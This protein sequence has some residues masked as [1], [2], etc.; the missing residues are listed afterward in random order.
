MDNV[1]RIS[2]RFDIHASPGTSSEAAHVLKYDETFAVFDNFGNIRTD[3]RGDQ[4]L[5]HQGTRYLNRYRFLL[6]GTEPL[7]LSSE[8]SQDNLILSVDLTNPDLYREDEL[9]VDQHVLHITR[10]KFLGDGV[11]YDRVE[12]ANYTNALLIVRFSV[13]FEA[14]FADIFE[15]R[16]TKRA[17]RGRFTEPHLT[18][19]S[20]RLSYIGLDEVTR[21]TCLSFDPAPVELT[22]Y[23]AEFEAQLA[24]GERKTQDIAVACNTETHIEPDCYDRIYTTLIEERTQLD[25][26]RTT[27]TTANE[28]FNTWLDRS[29][30]D[31]RMMTTATDYGP[32]PYAGVPWFSTVFGRD[33]IITALETL[34]L[35][36]ELARG[37]LTFLAATQAS[38]IDPARDAE[39]GKIVH[40]LRQGE[41]AALGEVPFGRYYGSVD[42]TP[43][44]VL[45]AGH[46][47]DRTGDLNTITDLWPHLERALSWI[48]DYGDLDGDG[49]VEYA[50]KS[51]SGLTNQGWKDSWDC[52]FHADGSFAEAPIA[53][54]EVQGYVFAAKQA[55]AAIATA[56][57]KFE[58]A[59][60]LTAEADAL[61]QRF[62]EAFWVEEL[63]TYAIALDVNKAPCRIRTSNPGHCLFS[64][65]ALPR[66]ADRVAASL[67]STRMFSGWGVRTLATGEARYNPM[68]Y[69]NGSV[70]P[71]DNA[72]I[73]AGLARYGHSDKALEILHG[74]F[75]TSL[76]FRNSRLPELFCGFDRQ[77]YAGPTR[78]PT[79]AS[80][81]SWAAAVVFLL[82]GVAIGA[83]IDASAER[84]I[85]RNPKIPDWL[86]SMTIANL[87]V[88]QSSV[89]LHLHR[90]EHDVAVNVTHRTGPAEIII[91]K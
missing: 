73:A 19:D 56:L 23:E 59:D 30:A 90:Y 58:Q 25:H 82:C 55:A 80:P 45:L 42:A 54:C 36:P 68:S 9:L 83:E 18:G 48:D 26:D 63:S 27:I 7:L 52:I 14:D 57:G 89:G 11:L 72:L 39:P 20:V 33:G 5:Y 85:L 75:D 34:W 78:Y 43:L 87:Q 12:L 77:S 49:F 86:D 40:E 8:V 32:Y 65:I 37:V 15:V 76:H 60:R 50:R 16:G 46:Y 28:Q 44:F 91:V 88:G 53:L 24:P 10:T 74:L 2:D 6:G 84:L 31:L 21:T 71:H 41:M 38:D 70:W 35:Y 47:F 66:H 51:G 81:Q 64:G 17:A 61:Q 3:E 13:V 67:L 4:G 79:A 62:A 1:V 69:H 22:G 29:L